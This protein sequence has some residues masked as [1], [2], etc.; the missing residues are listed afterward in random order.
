MPTSRLPSARSAWWWV[1]PRARWAFLAAPRPRRGSQCGE[2][3]QVAG[4]HQPLVAHAAL[5]TTA[6]RSPE[7]L[8]T[9][10]VPANALRP[11]AVA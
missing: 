8:V 6:L 11:L 10:A 7:D 3:P 4:V 5:A 9:G 1:A 2:R